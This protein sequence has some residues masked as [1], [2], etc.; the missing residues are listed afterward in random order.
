MRPANVL[1]VKVETRGEQRRTGEQPHQVFYH[2]VRFVSRGSSMSK[3]SC[4]GLE[5][6]DIGLF[7]LLRAMFESNIRRNRRCEADHK[8]EAASKCVGRQR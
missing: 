2:T 1:V 6:L 5:V 3:P 8:V 4:D 7:Q